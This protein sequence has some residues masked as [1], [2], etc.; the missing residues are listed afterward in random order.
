M[1]EDAAFD[2]KGVVAGCLAGRE[3]S[4]IA[5]VRHYHGLVFSLCLR[6]LGQRQDAEDATQETFSRVLRSLSQWDSTRRFEPWLLTV[7]GNRCRTKM[8]K[9]RRQVSHSMEDCDQIESATT[10]SGLIL[11]E[12]RAGLRLLREEYRTVFIKFHLEHRSFEEIAEDLGMP[13]ATVKT[14]CHRA[15]K[16]LADILSRRGNLLREAGLV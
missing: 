16:E 12:V 9:R 14:W 13:Y 4:M 7:A 8:A 1:T 10:D 15:R 6:L 2:I 3:S 11:E 5:L